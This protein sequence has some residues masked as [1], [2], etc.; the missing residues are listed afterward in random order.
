ME[1]IENK[2]IYVRY[3]G[4]INKYIDDGKYYIHTKTG[5]AYDKY[6]NLFLGKM[7]ENIIELLEAGDIVEYTINT[8]HY[9][10]GRIKEY[11]DKNQ[12]TYLGVE[13]FELKVL[14]IKTILTKEQYE[15]NCF[16]LE[17]I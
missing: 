15:A 17:E 1:E 11:K 8:N 4:I 10:I 9:N 6:N 3:N 7:S 5:I 12:D 2:Y 13:G 14:K 16:R